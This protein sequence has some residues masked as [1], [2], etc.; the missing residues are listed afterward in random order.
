M[1]ST[2]ISRRFAFAFAWIACGAAL[3]P[4]A[5]SGATPRTITVGPTGPP[6]TGNCYVFGMGGN[7]GSPWTPFA[8]YVYQNIPA[9]QLKVGDTLAF[10][11][12]AVNDTDVQLDIALAATTSN[13]G[14]TPGQAFKT[15]VANTQ[16]PANP[17]GD[18]VIGNYEM[19]F[20][21]QAPF[22]FPGGGLI[23]R[24]GNPSPTYVTDATCTGNLVGANAT[25]PS[26][27]FVERAFRDP[28]GF[29]PW[30][31]TDGFDVGA[32]RLI[33]QP[34]S[35]SFSFGS[36][37]RNKSKGTAFLVAN[38]PGPGTLSL[39]G[40]GVKTQRAAGGATAS[41]NV[42]NAGTVVLPIKAKGKAKK[43]L[44]KTGKAKV[45]VNVTFAPAG[46]PPGDP[47]TQSTTVKLVKKR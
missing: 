14:D 34:A 38:V 5:G 18:T 25:D 22:S 17:R 31:V 19:Q 9:F 21:A 42:I 35:D 4:T 41:V 37:S 7:N 15:V 3:L 10:D 24:F 27:L 47:K 2:R 26:G 11:T 28:D 40:K 1:N 32:F 43:K 46:D 30:A 6:S 39:T 45:T 33:L 16:T 13:G 20:Q 44:N 8:A 36:L 29:A 12:N 23:I